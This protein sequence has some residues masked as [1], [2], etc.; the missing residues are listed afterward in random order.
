MG[1]TKLHELI[2]LHGI[3]PIFLSEGGV[4]NKHDVLS[5]SRK[6]SQ[7][8]RVA[9]GDEVCD[10]SL[11]RM[12]RRL[13]CPDLPGNFDLGWLWHVVLS[14]RLCGVQVTARQNRR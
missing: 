5:I 1:A 7:H 8:R 9:L 12:L 11:C 6:T 10:H 3:R 13:L 2:S 14:D 4:G